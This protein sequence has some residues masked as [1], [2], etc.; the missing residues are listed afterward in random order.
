MIIPNET[1]RGFIADPLLA[2]FVFMETPFGT[3]KAP[4]SEHDAFMTPGCNVKS[5][6]MAGLGR[7]PKY[8]GKLAEIDKDADVVTV[9]GKEMPGEPAFVWI[10]TLAQYASIWRCD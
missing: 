3:P 7:P 8:F 5:E 2:A 1:R 4:K 9:M 6:E 10:G